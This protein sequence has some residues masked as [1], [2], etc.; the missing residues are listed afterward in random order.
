MLPFQN[1][2]V[3]KGPLLKRRHFEHYEWRKVIAFEVQLASDTM[4]FH[5]IHLRCSFPKKNQATE[6]K[7]TKKPFKFGQNIV[8]V[9]LT[10]FPI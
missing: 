3:P 8:T 7:S 6:M 2:D 10:L 9:F 5:S 1:Q 4:A